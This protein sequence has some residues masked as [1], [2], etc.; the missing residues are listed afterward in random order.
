MLDLEIPQSFLPPHSASYLREYINRLQMIL[1]LPLAPGK[2]G[3]KKKR[4]ISRLFLITISET[5][6]RGVSYY[7]RVS[8]VA[9]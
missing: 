3:W 6:E 1:M 7:K 9:L 2:T 4:K 5:E 8:Y